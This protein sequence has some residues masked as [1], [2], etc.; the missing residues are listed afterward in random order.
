[1]NILITEESER[2][3]DLTMFPHVGEEIRLKIIDRYCRKEEEINM[4]KRPPF[5][6]EK[7]SLKL[8]ATVYGMSA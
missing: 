4:V 1:M 2:I 8:M 5:S 7:V 3:L 6:K